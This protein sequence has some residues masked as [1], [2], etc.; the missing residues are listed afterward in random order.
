M[1]KSLIYGLADPTDHRIWY[2]GVTRKVF[3]RVKVHE[4][5]ERWADLSLQYCQWRI[6]LAKR[7]LKPELV[8]VDESVDD[9]AHKREQEWIKKGLALGWPL[10]NCVADS[11]LA[12]RELRNRIVADYIHDKR[13]LDQISKSYDTSL[14]KF[15]KDPELRKVG[16]FE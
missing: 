2:I 4:N 7:G 5:P 16:G 8:Y 13:L 14:L 6:S 12:E 9:K 15:A 1:S 11:T 3:K 10:T